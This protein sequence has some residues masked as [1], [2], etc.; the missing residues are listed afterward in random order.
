MCAPLPFLDD[1]GPRALEQA[2]NGEMIGLEEVP[3]G[4]WRVI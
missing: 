4:P 3:D 2:L 1:G